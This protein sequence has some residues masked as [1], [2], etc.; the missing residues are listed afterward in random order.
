M[1]PD[2]KVA[3]PEST[4]KSVELRAAISRL[5]DHFPPALVAVDVLGLSYAEAARALRVCNGTMP[6]RLHRAPPGCPG[7]A[8][9]YAGV[10][11]AA[12]RPRDREDARQALLKTEWLCGICCS[13]C[14]PAYR[15]RNY[16]GEHR[17]HRDT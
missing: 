11:F 4:I 17:E 16:G 12:L 14:Q 10:S 1:L 3:S 7:A 5:P 2:L 15:Q 6:S 8:R 9:W 13:D